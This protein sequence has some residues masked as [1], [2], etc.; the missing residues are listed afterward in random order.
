[1]MLSSSELVMRLNGSDASEG[2]FDL[3]FGRTE[4]DTWVKSLAHTSGAL[5]APLLQRFKGTPARQSVQRKSTSGGLLRQ[6]T[7]RRHSISS[8]TGWN[9]KDGA[10]TPSVAS[11]PR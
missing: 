10:C 1:M 6:L 4:G 5:V 7:P 3:V 2:M 8:F 11:T 9:N